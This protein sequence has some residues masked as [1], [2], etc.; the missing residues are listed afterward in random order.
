MELICLDLRFRLKL[1]RFLTWKPGRLFFAAATK[2][3]K[4]ARDCD[5]FYQTSIFRKRAKPASP[6]Q[7][8]SID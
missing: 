2:V 4:F 1:F 7:P 5:C 8:A 6:A 3:R